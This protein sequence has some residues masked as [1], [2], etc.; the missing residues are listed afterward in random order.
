MR[1]LLPQVDSLKLGVVEVIV[2]DNSSSDETQEYL[3]ELLLKHAC[4]TVHRNEKNIGAEGNFYNL[5]AYAKGKYL[6]MLGDDDVVSSGALD[7]VLPLLQEGPDYIALNFRSSDE[8]LEKE[9]VKSWVLLNDVNVNDIYECLRIVPHFAVGFISG[10]IARRELFNN[11]SREQ[12]EFFSQWGLSLMADRYVSLSKS[13]HGV[14][15]S[16]PLIKTRKPPENEYSPTFSY[17]TWFFAGSDAVLAYLV[18]LGVISSVYASRQKGVLLRSIAPKRIAFER[19]RGVFCFSKTLKVLF[20]GYRSRWEFWLICLPL[21]TLPFV[22]SLAAWIKR[23]NDK[24]L[25]QQ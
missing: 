13:S 16:D 18:N 1:E 25:V 2:S 24:T 6:W 15:L 14:V 3:Q 20:G 21:M 19:S 8:N 12:Y 23:N 5:P 11:L 7:K 9:G 10:W 22:G 17:F 4:L